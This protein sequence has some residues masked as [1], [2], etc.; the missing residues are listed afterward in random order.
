MSLFAELKRRNVIKVAVLYLVAAWVLLQVTE[1]L[2]SL[3]PVPEWAGALVVMLLVL[4][5]FPVL[6]FSWVY[7]LT[8][9]GLKREKDIDRSQS[10]TAHTGRKINVLIVVLLVIAIGVVLVDRLIPET[11][12]V[13][14]EP[15]AQDD[16]DVADAD[17]SVLVAEKFAP[18]PDRSIA[19]LPF[20]SMSGDQENEYFADGLS[21]EILNFLA[22]VQDLRVTART[23]SFS[24]KGKN[25][26]VRSVGEALNV[27]HILEGSVRRS[28]ERARIT[29]QLVRTSDGYHLWSETYD[30]TLEDTFEVQ[31]D[32]AESVTRALG[33]IMDDSQRERM[34]E[35]GVRDV[36]AFIAFQRGRQL[37]WDAHT[38]EI[39]MGMMG[40]A[41]DEF[42]EAVRLEPRFAAAYFLRSDFYAHSTTL[43]DVSET[44]RQATFSAYLDDLVAASEYARSAAQR[45]LIEVDRA[46]ASSNWRSL[47]ERFD[48][49]LESRTCADAVWLEVAPAFGFAEKSIA[50]SRRMIECD[51]LNFYSYYTG[52]IGALWTG[53]PEEAMAFVTD[54]LAVAPDHP[55]LEDIAVTTLIA[56]QR[57]DEAQARI[58]SRDFWNKDDLLAMLA[59]A[60]GELD[61]AGR[62]AAS[63]VE[64]AAGW[65]KIYMGI[66]INAVTG[67]REAA[68]KGAAW[69]DSL[70]LGQ[71]M[72]GALTMECLC[73]APFDL[74]AT[75]VFRQRLEEAGFDWPPP[76]IIEYPAMQP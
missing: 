74:D 72:L 76:T 57:F 7:E 33:V 53:K 15:V 27:A 24:F 46:L 75:P 52:G 64:N 67:N 2:S 35:A 60:K 59:A 20:V 47:P 70:P 29:A 37:F 40:E 56:Q 48:V 16:E 21:E 30:R 34:L 49:A 8:P 61:S 54:G 14:D 36:E 62:L 32:I 68:N 13:I 10:V 42:G 28:G 65:N 31:T 66:Q 4:G 12:Q 38:N 11:A 69:L 45:A 63:V 18:P 6:I 51:P 3:L 71:L 17:P 44:D 43:P 26:D 39:D 9:E 1:V 19:V 22:G 25:E 5:F 50:Y 58:E 41:A 55:F 23:S 73:G